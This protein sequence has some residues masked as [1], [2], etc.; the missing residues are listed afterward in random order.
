MP[1]E[2]QWRWDP[3]SALC[4]NAQDICFIS[5]VFFSREMYNYIQYVTVLYISSL[6]ESICLLHYYLNRCRNLPDILLF[7]LRNV[8]NNTNRGFR[9]SLAIFLCSVRRNKFTATSTNSSSCI[10]R[11]HRFAGHVCKIGIVIFQ[12]YC[13]HLQFRA[14]FSLQYFSARDEKIP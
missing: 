14:K 6:D 1:E 8:S 9:P 12:S 5:L 7:S 3:F 4:Q 2:R 11:L 10:V 13:F